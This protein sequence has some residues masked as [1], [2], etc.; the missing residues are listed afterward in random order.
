[1][2]VF[3]LPISLHSF[4]VKTVKAIEAK[5]EIASGRSL[6][7]DVRIKRRI[8]QSVKTPPFHGGMRGSRLP[9]AVQGP[10][11]RDRGFFCVW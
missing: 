6:N 4:P 2:P 5:A 10:R 8:G 7:F 3:R 9:Y 1:M 11:S